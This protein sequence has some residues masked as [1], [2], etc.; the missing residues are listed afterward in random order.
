[1][2]TLP[3]QRPMKLREQLKECEVHNFTFFFF[4]KVKLFFKKEMLSSQ[5]ILCVKWRTLRHFMVTLL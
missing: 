5:R 1:M 2:W 3:N 4:V